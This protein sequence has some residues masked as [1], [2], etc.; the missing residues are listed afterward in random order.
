MS[1]AQ[2]RTFSIRQENTWAR[3]M[4]TRRRVALVLTIVGIALVP[5]A[6]AAWEVVYPRPFPEA[7]WLRS[8]QR[9]CFG[10]EGNDLDAVIRAG[11]NVI[12]GGTNAAGIGFAGGPF[13]LGKDGAI[14][15]IRSGVPVP[16]ATLNEL[17][18]RVDRAHAHGAK[19]LG[20]VIRF[21][22]TPWIQ[23]EHPDWQD[24]NSPGARP[25]TLAQL[26]DSGVLGCWNSPYG[27]WFI[28]SQV[29]LLKRLDWDGYNMDGFGCWS[30]CFCPYCRAA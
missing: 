24:L 16:E 21:Y 14:V 6:P 28:K 9:L 19:V 26:K 22:M 11:T 29:E 25:I 15:D 17:R 2:N 20:E 7:T 8:H 1:V 10:V 12:C 4:K 27:D 23:A 18:A 5:R 13:I 30:Q 3:T